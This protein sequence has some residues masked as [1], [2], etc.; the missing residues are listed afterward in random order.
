MYLSSIQIQGFKTFA[1]K[2]TVTF[3]QG[4]NKTNTLSV[5]VGPNGSGKSNLADAIRWCLGEQSMK[6]LRGR[7]T[8]DII[9]SG[10]KGHGR[11][12]YAEVAMTINN[13][14]GAMQVDYREVTI[15][16]RLY[17]DGESEYLLNGKKVR[18]TDIHLL[19]AEAGIGQRS[20]TVI[21]QGM[22]D[23]VLTSSPEERKIFFDDAT[24]VRGLQI[25]RHQSM[26]KLKKSTEHLV[27]VE[28][29]VAEIEPRLRMLKRQ[30]RRLEKREEVELKLSSI[31][32]SYYGTVWW[33]LTD[34]L[35][36]SSKRQE[37]INKQIKEKRTELEAGDQELAAY[38]EQTKNETVDQSAISKAQQEYR[39]KQSTLSAARKRQ[40]EAERAL[41]LAKVQAQSTW[42]PLPLHE[43]IS[44][45]ESLH[46][47]HEDLLQTL[48]NIQSLEELD[49]V[50]KKIETVFTRSKGL[51]IRLTKP[52]PDDY[53]ADPTL[54]AAHE[55]TTSEVKAIEQEVKQAEKHIDAVQKEQTT[56]RSVFFDMQRTLRALQTELHT[57]EGKKNH[58]EIDRARIETRLEGIEREIREETPKLLNI[59]RREK[60]ESTL[61]DIDAT[62]AE[63][64]K[65]RHQL[66]LIG[67]IDSETVEEHEQ[68]EERYTFLNEQLKDLQQAIQATE[69]VIDELD[70][71]IQKQGEQAF[72]KI[73]SEFQKYFKLLFG[74]GSCSLIKLQ[75]DKEPSQK[76]SL[77]RA[78]ES[79]AEEK[80]EELEEESLA[81]AALRRFKK[82]RETVSGIE[83]QAT[84]PGKKLKS[85]NL[86]SGGERA[87]TS[88]AL[89]SA[90]M[91]TNPSPFVILDEVDAALDEANTIRFANIL[92]ELQKLTQF[93]V[94]TH[95][96]AT[97]EKA[98]LLY[99]VTM[100]DDGVSNLLS[101]NLT[102]IEDAGSARR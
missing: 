91:A 35:T 34:D 38:E 57:L 42:S 16:R 92:G 20:Y 59:I 40:F 24:G 84:P 87:L 27:E 23:H 77:D 74:G 85:L 26:L 5:I 31:R 72:K 48:K 67:G 14:D 21:G 69:K 33:Q 71:R 63:M 12:G 8:A 13:D 41:E 1:K 55:K 73:N 80:I 75:S 19:L 18:L 43:I 98:D 52:N 29:L 28:M 2:T 11:S 6:Q 17:R 30:M 39:D 66:E 81:S 89:L 86:L 54:V 15:T 88:I 101:V 64:H 37:A 90:I 58:E 56:D 47:V 53:K 70:T 76:V 7:K 49:A 78:L 79:L 96:R 44:E 36:A 93:I 100:G 10:S 82:R 68:T 22:I 51:K 32:S 50:T 83:I 97:M 62:R 9:F 61:K 95:N 45:L 94:I 3:P 60:P 65:L 102:D 46:T 4:P 99:G 25:K